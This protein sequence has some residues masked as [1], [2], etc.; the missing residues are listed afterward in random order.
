MTIQ[1]LLGDCLDRMAGLPTGSVPI[2]LCD[3]PYDL[4]SVSR[5]GSARVDGTGPYVSWGK[6]MSTSPPHHQYLTFQSLEEGFG[7]PMT[8]GTEGSQV[9]QDICFKVRRKQPER[10]DVVYLETLT[11]PSHTRLMRRPTVSTNPS[12]TA[13]GLS[14]LSLPMRAIICGSPID[15]L[16]MVFTRSVFVSTLAGAVFPRP[17]FLSHLAWVKLEIRLTSQA[18]ESDPFLGF[19]LS[20]SILAL[21]RA[22][23]ASAV[24]S[25]CLLSLKP[26][27]AVF[28]QVSA[29]FGFRNVKGPSP[30]ITLPH[31]GA[32][33]VPG[34]FLTVGRNL[35]A[36]FAGSTYNLPHCILLGNKWDDTSIS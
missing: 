34:C 8:R 32:G 5:G 31:A 33:T 2:V 18:G 16:W 26:L 21:L 1:L 28:T 25:P 15:V 19:Q 23:Y 17:L 24:S 7:F 13:F 6:G 27:A 30:G 14:L 4:T 36:L 10:S 3:P 20:R 9:R 11:M 12:I 35:K 29:A 22:I